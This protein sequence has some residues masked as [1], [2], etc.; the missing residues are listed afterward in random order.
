VFFL[1]AP[2]PLHAGGGGATTAPQQAG[3]PPEPA[4]PP[5]AA[6]GW[7][8]V[9][10]AE[11][12]KKPW[13]IAW[14]PDGRPLLTAKGG[15]L[16]TV[17]DGRFE[18][19]PT[20]GLPKVFTSGQGALMDI[21]LHPQF[22]ENRRVYMTLS[23]GTR[24]ANHTILVRGIFDGRKV[25]GIETLFRVEPMKS[26]DEHFGSRLLWLPDGTLLM[27]IG[28]G[29]N[30]P[31]RVGGILA[32]EQAQNGR[33]HLG[34][35]LR[36]TEDGKAAPDNP[37]LS[38]DGFKPEIWSYGHRNIQGM[39]LDPETGRVWVNEHGPKGGDELNQVK[40]GEN[41]GWPLQT[42]G[43]DYR[44]GELIGNL[45]VPGAAQPKAVWTPAHAPSG[46]AFYT[47]DRLPNW[48]GS[49]FS[50]GLVSKD[51][52]RVA[53]DGDGNVIGQ[54]RLYIARRVRDVRQGPD[55]HLYA[56]TD[57]DNGRLLRIEPAQ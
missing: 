43:R 55:G 19:I 16:H 45:S 27:S 41:H 44:T 57:E 13:G 4:G 49:L 33:S 12:L 1:V 21:A 15:T 5:P 28:D 2:V 30:P 48:R 53:L 9:T 20:D 32:R 46:L 29:G 8:A 7:R 54:N 17:R 35:I 14:L 39:T 10:V 31:R 47:G 50:G 6:Q 3:Q 25:G 26:G 24:E 36:L 51:I 56:L 38:R 40:G 37:F 34:A 23:T 18:R 11:G 22:A 42:Q 52:R